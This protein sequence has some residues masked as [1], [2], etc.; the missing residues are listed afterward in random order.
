LDSVIFANALTGPSPPGG[1]LAVAAQVVIVSARTAG[2][3]RSPVTSSA[4][5]AMHPAGPGHGF[6]KFLPVLLGNT[7]GSRQASVKAYF[8]DERPSRQPIRADLAISEKCAI[9][10]RAAVA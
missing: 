6:M 2:A 7:N 5:A 9:L 1:L 8:L 4:T 3:S 10:A